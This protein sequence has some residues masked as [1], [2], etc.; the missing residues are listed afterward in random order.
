MKRNRFHYNIIGAQRSGKT[1]LSRNFA[2]QYAQ[3]QGGVMVY[4]YGKDSD[5]P[6]GE[7]LYVEPL[8]FSEH[9]R[10]YYSSKEK[11]AYY[12]A[13]P[14][15]HYLRLGRNG[16]KVIHMKDFAS[17][18]FKKKLKLKMVADR[19][20]ENAFFEAVYKYCA[21]MLLIFDDCKPI[22]QHGLNSQH[23]RIMNSKNHTGFAS[24][25]SK[26]HGK[27]IDI[28]TI[29][30]AVDDV[31]KEIWVYL[32]DVILLKTRVSVKGDKIKNAILE[33][34]IRESWS[35]LNK[36]PQYT[37]LRISDADTESGYKL[38]NVTIK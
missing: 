17:F 2:T 1:Y 28:I 35:Y 15:I 20:E 26:F 16:D 27:G 24:S 9:M 25:N 30:H 6:D 38:T 33:K 14:E 32:S 19:K 22:F 21:H 29:F 8:S 37:A 7:Y 3:K 23:V 4:N 10:D 11:K 36:A 31:T 13:K 5:F 18:F 12:K 34:L